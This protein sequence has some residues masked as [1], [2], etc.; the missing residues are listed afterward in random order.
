MATISNAQTAHNFAN[1]INYN[2]NAGNLYWIRKGENIRV[3]YSYGPHFPIALIDEAA[4][5]CLFTTRGYSNSTARH[6]NDVRAALPG[7]YRLIFCYNPEASDADNL[8]DYADG[9]KEQ[10]LKLANART[11]ATAERYADEIRNIWNTANAYAEYKKLKPAA[12]KELKKI[13]EK[14]TSEEG[15]ARLKWESDHAREIAA[16]AA[17]R[18]AAKKA[19]EIAKRV[20]E[21]EQ[22]N[23]EYLN[24]KDCAENVPL[25]AEARK[26]Y[27]IIK[28]GKG[29]EIPLIEAQRFAGLVLSGDLSGASVENYR[30]YSAD[31]SRV[32]IGCHT[33]KTDYLKTWAAKVL[34]M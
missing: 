19:R 25:R 2:N 7:W 27:T 12:L 10:A 32:V 16:K 22:G 11:A 24:Y 1:N 26:G 23:R 4:R 21:W 9:I 14:A 33:F 28:T 30:V 15:R 6:I 5:V 31:A 29:V 18:A 34:K 13:H 3:I 17:K 8:K 20:K